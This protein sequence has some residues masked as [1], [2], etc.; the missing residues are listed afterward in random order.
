MLKAA[1]VLEVENLTLTLNGK[2]IIRDLSFSLLHGERVCL[3]GASGCG[4]SF[5]ARA[6]TG[7]LP[8]Q[9]IIDG[10]IRVNGVNVT[11]KNALVRAPKSRVAA[12]FQDSSVAL[13][14]LVR[15]GKQLA[16][17]NRV[18]PADTRDRLLHGVGLSD[19]PDLMQRFPAEISG[20]QL[21]RLCMVLATLTKSN[22][23]VAD[24]P[25][26]ALDVLAQQQVINLLLQRSVQPDAPA[27]LFIT[28]DI[29]VAAQICQRAIVM[30]D[31]ELVESAPLRQL[32]RT[33]VHP[34]TRQL[35]AAATENGN[36]MSPD[37]TRMA[38]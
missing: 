26:T 30:A 28:H 15:I 31:G 11:R 8:A 13:N 32:L 6:I 1:P 38:V 19:I 7:T 23:L 12:V 3:L 34:Y 17:V 14:P 18:L 25:T 37:N 9:T 35:I 20:G 36:L 29:G 5:T 2:T 27:L 22:V 24:E 16:L 21:Q 33:P 4:K 10:V